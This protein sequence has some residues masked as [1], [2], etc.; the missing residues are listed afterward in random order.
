MEFPLGRH[1]LGV[2]TRDFNAGV[3]TGFVV[4]LDDISGVDLTGSNTAVVWS[5]GTWETAL[6]PTI[7]SSKG[8]E[9]GIFLLEAEPRLMRGVL[10]H[11]FSAFG[12]IV[13]FVGCSVRVVAFGEDE[14]VVTTSEWVR[15]HSDGLEI[16]IGIV[17][18]GL[19]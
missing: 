16:D 12:T 7:R 14:D 2:D 5:L 18:G 10:L 4:R 8:V 17:S 3:Q 6:R 1:D 15:V 9:E 13:E 19:T 11:Q